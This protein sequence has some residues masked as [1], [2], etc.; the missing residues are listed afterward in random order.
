MNCACC[1]G[2][3]VF[4]SGSEPPHLCSI[5]GVDTP[6][7]RDCIEYY[8]SCSWNEEEWGPYPFTVYQRQRGRQP[9]RCDA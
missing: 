8:S 1:G 9:H 2:V 4:F 6:Y 7:C 5:N 3:F